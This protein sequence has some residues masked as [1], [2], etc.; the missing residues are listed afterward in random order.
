MIDLTHL[1]QHL[2]D[3]TGEFKV[4][5]KIAEESLRTAASQQTGDA[6]RNAWKA[7]HQMLALYVAI[8]REKHAVGVYEDEPFHPVEDG[9]IP[10][11]IADVLS[12]TFEMLGNGNI[13]DPIRDS[14]KRYG[15]TRYPLEQRDIQVAI[16]YIRAAKARLIDDPAYTKTISQRYGVTVRAAQ[17]WNQDQGEL[18]G[19]LF[20]VDKLAARIKTSG[21]RYRNAPSE[22]AKPKQAI[23]RERK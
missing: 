13:P 1:R 10:G 9:Y 6:A 3:L 4:A 15:Q 8:Q 12:Q 23:R 18:D 20:P 7:V 21:E 22:K 14:A 11:N 2:K 19:R 17:K 5:T 16:A